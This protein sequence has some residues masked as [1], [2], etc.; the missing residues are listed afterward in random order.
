MANLMEDDMAMASKLSM[1]VVNI[2]KQVCDVLHGFLSF[3]M[4]YE[5][6]KTHNMLFLM[7]NPIFKSFRL[8]FSFI[9]WKQVISMVE[10]YDKQYLFS[11][12]LK[13]HHVFHLV[14]EFE[15]VVDWLNDDFCFGIFEMIVGIGELAKELVN[16][17]LQMFWKYYI[18][19]KDIKCP[20]EWWGKHESLFPINIF[21]VII[22]KN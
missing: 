1:H 8:V 15:T 7:L 14:L 12:S 11:I 3:V 17:A 6:N 5:K 21:D 10:T 18:D 2:R 9:G 20:L 4:K 19:A 22:Q 13:C 16:M